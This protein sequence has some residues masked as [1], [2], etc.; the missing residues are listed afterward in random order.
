VVRSMR[1]V[2]LMGLYA[3][4]FSFAQTSPDSE[5]S[6]TVRWTRAWNAAA[7]SSSFVPSRLARD[8]VRAE[9]VPLKGE[10]AEAHA[11]RSFAAAL[12]VERALRFGYTRQEAG[13]RL[14]QSLRLQESVGAENEERMS[15]KLAK[16]IRENHPAGRMRSAS[17]GKSSKGKTGR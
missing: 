4:S 12:R 11:A 1:S 7:S 6:E 3:A 15:S 13:A 8:I 17:G 10:E 5:I 9:L 2:L 16:A 14:R